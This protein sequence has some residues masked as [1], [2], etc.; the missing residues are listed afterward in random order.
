[1][2]WRKETFKPKEAK[3]HSNINLHFMLFIH[4]AD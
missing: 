4:L 2:I 1:M 3:Q